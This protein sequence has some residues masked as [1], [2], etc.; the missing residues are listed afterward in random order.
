MYQRPPAPNLTDQQNSILAQEWPRF[1]EGELSRRRTAIET[2]MAENDISQLILYG[3]GGR[4]SAVP[5]LTEWSVTT[6]V[7]AILSPDERESLIAL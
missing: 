5:W 6:E 1:S 7:V 4:G 3:A 2:V